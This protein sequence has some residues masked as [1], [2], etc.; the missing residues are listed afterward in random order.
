MCAVLIREYTL[1]A[2]SDSLLWKTQD[3]LCEFARGRLISSICGDVQVNVDRRGYPRKGSDQMS[4]EAFSPLSEHGPLDQRSGSWTSAVRLF[5]NKRR[6]RL[7]H[8]KG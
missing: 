7:M 4:S 5:V 2:A 1:I 6:Q 3:P 8:V